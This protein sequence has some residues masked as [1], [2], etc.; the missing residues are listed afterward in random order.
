MMHKE[1]DRDF[2]RKGY[3]PEHA[4]ETRS[5]TEKRR[6]K[7]SCTKN[8]QFSI[9]CILHYNVVFSYLREGT[10]AGYTNVV[11]RVGGMLAAYL[12]G[13]EEGSLGLVHQGSKS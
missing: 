1:T 13:A 3:A 4:S 8:L 10:A 7:Q 5:G 6:R 11:G 12:A 9:K 2:I